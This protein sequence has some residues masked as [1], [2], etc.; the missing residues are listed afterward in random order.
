MCFSGSTWFFLSLNRR[1]C[2]CCRGENRTAYLATAFTT[3]F[4]KLTS[5]VSM[6]CLISMAQQYCWNH[7]SRVL[8]HHSSQPSDTATLCCMAETK[9]CIFTKCHGD[10]LLNCAFRQFLILRDAHMLLVGQYCLCPFSSLMCMSRAIGSKCR[11]TLFG[12]IYHSIG[13]VL[14]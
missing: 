9:A 1:V 3:Y 5:I 10:W 8:Q 13:S 11:W 7:S 12:A 6:P 2:V 14:L 4:M